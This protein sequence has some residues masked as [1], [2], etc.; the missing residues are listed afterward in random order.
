MVLLYLYNVKFLSDFLLNIKNRTKNSAK[1]EVQDSCWY[2]EV[3]SELHMKPHFTLQYLPFHK[4]V[5]L[6]C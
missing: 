5:Q 3:N 6:Y 4:Q 2:S 1:K